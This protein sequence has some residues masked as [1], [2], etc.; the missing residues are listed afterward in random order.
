MAELVGTF[1]FVFFASS[2]VVVSKL[3]DNLGI[4]PI[5][6]AIGFV[7]ISLIYALRELSGGF[8]NPTITIALWLTKKLSGV[9]T[10][11]YLLSQIAGSFLA[12]EFVIFIFG[13]PALQMQLGGPVFGLGVLPQTVLAIEALVSAGLVFIVFATM[14]DKRGNSGMG[15]LVLGLYLVAVTVIFWPLSGASFNPVRALGP[16]VLSHAYSAL[17]IFIIGPLIGSLAAIVYE[18]VF[19]ENDKKK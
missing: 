10:V 16:L 13:N 17:A 18:Y 5:A 15:P 12:A 9:R 7:Y 11:F 1:L 6:F 2:V 14:F 3:Y 4:L 19:I 8:L